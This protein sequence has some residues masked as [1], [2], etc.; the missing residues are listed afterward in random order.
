MKLFEILR[1]SHFRGKPFL[2]QHVG[3]ERHEVR[4]VFEAVQYAQRLFHAFSLVLKPQKLAIQ[5]PE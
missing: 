1:G 3:H 2:A 4:V 5:V